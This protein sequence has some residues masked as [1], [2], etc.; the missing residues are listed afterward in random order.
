MP[1]R[2]VSAGRHPPKN[3]K[4]PHGHWYIPFGGMVSH[5]MLVNFIFLAY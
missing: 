4:H 2:E 5:R 1:E 3:G